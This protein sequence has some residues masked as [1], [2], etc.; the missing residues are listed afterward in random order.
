MWRRRNKRVRVSQNKPY[1]EKG[2]SIISAWRGFQEAGTIC[3]WCWWIILPHN[4]IDG[5]NYITAI[6]QMTGFPMTIWKP[7]TGTSGPR[8]AA[9]YG[10]PSVKVWYQSKLPF[11][12]YC[13]Y[14][15]F[16]VWHLL[17]SNDLWRPPNQS[18]SSTSNGH[19]MLHIKDQVSLLCWW[20][21]FYNFSQYDLW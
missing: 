11:W 14:K 1:T 3:D 18:E 20:Y 9:Q 12:R 16:T 8:H 7:N 2:F 19:P 21:C 4:V 10:Q 17:T 13:F 6:N 15:V 5:P